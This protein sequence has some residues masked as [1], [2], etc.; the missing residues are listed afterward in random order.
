MDYPYAQHAKK[1]IQQYGLKR[2]TN[3]EYGDK[4]CPN[5]GGVDRFYVNDHNGLL[6]HHCRQGCDDLE[7]LKAMQ[8]DGALPKATYSVEVVPY[9]HKKNIPL[10]GARLE[11]DTV[12]VPLSDV[13]TGEQK[14]KQEIYPNGRKKFSKGMTKLNAGCF[15]GD[16]TDILY[17]CDGWAD[18][19]AIRSSTEQQHSLP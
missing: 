14:G 17:I 18:A 7:R 19:V 9:H 11:G 4:P 1:V 6:K 10:L 3:D 12:V 15:I 5:C 13:L 16:R 8:R 2:K